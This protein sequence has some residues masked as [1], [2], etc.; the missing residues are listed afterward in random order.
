MRC[1]PWAWASISTL[2]EGLPPLRHDSVQNLYII[3][4]FQREGTS[5]GNN[6]Y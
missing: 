3:Y 4:Y 5:M 1:D 2:T 6:N